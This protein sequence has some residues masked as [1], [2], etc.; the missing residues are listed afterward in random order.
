M[1]ESP[2]VL[3][4]FIDRRTDPQDR[5]PIFQRFAY[6]LGGLVYNL[7]GAGIGADL[8]RRLDRHYNAI[9]DGLGFRKTARAYGAFPTA[10]YSHSPAHAG[11]QQPGKPDSFP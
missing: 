6:G 11:A 9:R 2:P 4:T 5:I 1:K 10:P 3:S 8:L 7:L